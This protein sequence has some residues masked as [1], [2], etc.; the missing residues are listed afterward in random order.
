MTDDM[1]N[2]IL[3][4]L[5]GHIQS[6]FKKPIKAI[7]NGRSEMTYLSA[8]FINQLDL[9]KSKIVNS[10]L[11]KAGE[12][13][14]EPIAKLVGDLKNGINGIDTMRHLENNWID[15]VEI[16]GMSNWANANSIKGL[17][18]K[19]EEATSIAEQL[20]HKVRNNII[21]A[22]TEADI[23]NISERGKNCNQHNGM[24]AWKYLTGD[25]FY[26]QK[27]LGPYIRELYR[28]DLEIKPMLEKW[29]EMSISNE[30]ILANYHEVLVD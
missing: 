13:L 24:A 14:W 22:L 16:K 20:G 7:S 25:P 23:H 28:G 3:S 15:L 30:S 27:E 5:K 19:F 26:V 12:S 10:A 29:L 8:P 11:S 4:I 6:Q 17:L 18:V 1:K 2:K 9:Q 21:L